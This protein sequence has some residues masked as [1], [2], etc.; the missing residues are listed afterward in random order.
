MITV[1]VKGYFPEWIV[2]AI[3]RKIAYYFDIH[4]RERS[5]F[6]TISE[7]MIGESLACPS[8]VENHL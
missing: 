6:E 4:G 1:T 3:F 7:L 2:L 5:I 8:K